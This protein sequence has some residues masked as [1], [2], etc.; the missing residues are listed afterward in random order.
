MGGI[1]IADEHGNHVSSPTKQK[2]DSRFFV[3]WMITNDEIKFLTD[4]F[5]EAEKLAKLIK[6][7]AGLTKFTEESE[8]SKR[9]TVKVDKE[10]IESFDG[11]EIYQYTENFSSFEKA[12]DSGIKVRIT[13]KLGDYGLEPHPHMYVLLPFNHTSIKL[14]NNNGTVNQNMI[15][16]SGCF[17]EWIPTNED[18]LEI[19][20]TLA[21][22]SNSH[23]NALL[24]ILKGI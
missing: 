6:V 24:N 21:H 12:L 4:S 13:F 17:A 14:K 8:Y 9:K 10:K 7:M 11:F 20:I 23:C 16:G 1:R 3:E 22:A 15:L 18:I 2:N 19:I 5:L